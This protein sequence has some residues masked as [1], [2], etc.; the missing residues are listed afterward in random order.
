MSGKPQ[1]PPR[2]G[3]GPGGGDHGPVLRSAPRP[4]L[5]PIV[6]NE[7]MI[8]GNAWTPAS[9]L[10]DVIRASWPQQ[11][12]ELA[13]DDTPNAAAILALADDPRGL[14]W[15]RF[16][17][18]RVRTARPDRRDGI[19]RKCAEC[20]QVF[21]L[22]ARAVQIA[23][24]EE[25]GLPMRCRS[26]RDAL[27]TTAATRVR[28]RAD[29]AS[30]ASERVRAARPKTPASDTPAPSE[31]EPGEGPGTPDGCPHGL[32]WGVCR[33]CGPRHSRVT[34]PRSGTP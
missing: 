15:A 14:V 26:C 9:E 30:A 2:A 32:P 6:V 3:P 24:N 8:R 11:F 28:A 16:G 29:A 31:Y 20:G 7:L 23:A 27:G 12:D 4:D 22:S 33:S 18:V 1:E 34:A 17:A 13:V 10:A 19:A 21:Q 5:L 25:R